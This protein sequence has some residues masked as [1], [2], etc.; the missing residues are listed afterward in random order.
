MKIV[1]PWLSEMV[2]VPSDAEKVA[3]EISLRGF[4]VAS[5]ETRGLP[6][7][8]FEITPTKTPAAADIPITPTIAMF[9]RN[10]S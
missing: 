5:V 8:D 9:D 4:E 6:T 1:L 3:R 10:A 7:I 2:S